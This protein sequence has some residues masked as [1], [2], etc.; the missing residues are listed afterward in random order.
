MK[1]MGTT[2]FVRAYVDH[3]CTQLGLQDCPADLNVIE[4]VVLARNSA[5]HNGNLVMTTVEHDSKCAS[6]HNFA[7]IA[8]A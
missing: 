2:G 8:K 5:R 6:I 7:R 1:A 3:Y 4:Q